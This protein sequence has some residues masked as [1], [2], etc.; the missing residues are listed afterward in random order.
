MFVA[1]STVVA[2]PA[3]RRNRTT[4]L[5]AFLTQQ[6]WALNPSALSAQRLQ[7]ILRMALAVPLSS[8]SLAR[9]ALSARDQ[10]TLCRVFDV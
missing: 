10:I 5:F 6:Q 9:L 3:D 4:G 7:S 2:Q 8:A 1:P